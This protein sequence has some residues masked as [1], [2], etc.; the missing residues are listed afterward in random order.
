MSTG[1]GNRKVGRSQFG[2]TIDY[3]GYAMIHTIG[4]TEKHG[5]ITMGLLVHGF[6]YFIGSDG[7]LNYQAT[8]WNMGVAAGRS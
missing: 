7:A 6:R 4:T 3:G 8:P 1:A 2:H 5:C